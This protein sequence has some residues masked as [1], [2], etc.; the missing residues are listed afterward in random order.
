MANRSPE[1]ATV[2][3][4]LTSVVTRLR[5]AL[6]SSIRTEF[7]WEARPVAQIEVL[8]TLREAGGLRLGELAGRLHLAQSTISELVT[9]LADEGLVARDVDARDR[10]A[11]V[12]RLT[13]AGRSQLTGWDAAH[14]RRIGRALRTLSPEDQAQIAAALPSLDRLVAALIES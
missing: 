1:A 4:E 5:R 11:S 8:Q 13:P 7:P 10:R 9:V 3:R 12:V 6:R 2:T 14:R